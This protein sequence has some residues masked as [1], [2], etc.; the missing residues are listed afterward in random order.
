MIISTCSAKEATKKEESSSS[1]SERMNG[2]SATPVI[3]RVPFAGSEECKE[4]TGEK[5]FL[6]DQNQS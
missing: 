2:Y 4:R 3:G 1:S 5:K 6:V